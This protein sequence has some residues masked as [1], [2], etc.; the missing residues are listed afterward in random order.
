MNKKKLIAALLLGAAATNVNLA[1]AEEFL[2]GSEVPLTGN[3]ARVGTGM[4]EGIAVAAD[5]FNRKNPKH[6]IKIVT[7]DDET[8]PAKAVAAV[9]KLASQGVVA[10]T[11]GYGS[12][13]IGP[14][15]DA[16]NKAGL[17]YMTSGGVDEGLS[18]RG[19]KTFFRI[20][21]TRGYS[22]AMEGLFADMK[23]KSVSIVYNNKE[24]PA[25]LAKDVEKAMTAK[26]V[27]VS[28]HDFDPAITDFKPI[29]NKIKLQDKPDV[30][31][32]SGYEN[33][34]VGIIRAAKVLK[35]DVKAMVGVWSLA[36]IKM[37]QDFPDLMP[38]VYGTALL[39]YPA[40][41]RTADGKEF[42]DTYKKLFNKDPDYLGQFGY[43]QSQLLFDAI[44]RAFEAGTL[45]SGGL[46]AELRKTDKDTLIGRVKF[47]AKGDNPLFSHRM[48]QHQNGKVVI[49]WPKE[50]ASGAMNFPGVPW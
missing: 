47:D 46:E 45:K 26:G 50:S 7:I 34:Y 38:N 32:M 40:E 1:Q 3:L 10:F 12:N 39:P 20:N 25:A 30:I 49:V 4:M 6:K 11:G 15:S 17:V 22:L 13:I 14:A 37:Q 41:F 36:V 8:S 35:P 44:V 23:V 9:E 21:N 5:V 43:V 31:A 48:G 2:V 18:Q 19:Y 24:A 28:M 42:A 27:K 16:A 29:I 33:D